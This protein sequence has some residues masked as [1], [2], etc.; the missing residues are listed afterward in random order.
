MHQLFRILFHSVSGDLHRNLCQWGDV[1]KIHK[2]SVDF[3]NHFPDL[4][5]E[6][7]V[8]AKGPIV[9]TITFV[10]T[11]ACPLRCSYC[12]EC[13]KDHSARMSKETA[14]AAVD[15]ILHPERTK[16]YINMAQDKGVILDFIGGEPLLE[17]ELLEYI[18]DYFKMKVTMM[19]HPWKNH[20]MFSVTS[21]GIPWKD[22][23]VKRFIQKNAGRLSLTV[24]VDGDKTL[25]DS[26]RVFP[27]GSGSYEEAVEAV[28]FFRQYVR[29]TNTKAT[30]APGNIQYISKS[31]PHLF[32]LGFTDIHANCVYEEGWTL[33]DAQLFYSE[34]VKLAD[35]MVDEKVYEYGACSI[36]TDTIGKY[37]GPEETQNW[38]G[39]DGKMLAIGTDGRAFPCI[40]YMSYSLSNPDAKEIC[41]GDVW[42]GL[43]SPE[44]N[45]AL[46]C[47]T[48]L[49][50][51]SQS[52]QECLD[53]PV[54]TGCG[55][56]SAY[57]YDRYGTANK[58]ATF[59]CWTH[60]ARCMANAY[61]WNRIKEATGYDARAENN[62][63]P[64][65]QELL[66]GGTHA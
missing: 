32:S 19:D 37:Q 15:M 56:C 7:Q 22:P 25:H 24:T 10:V 44:E 16:G 17:P 11:E 13:N 8:G 27:D 64:D 55:W 66:R 58:R 54:S 3:A 52:T 35:W 29:M 63:H 42:E 31:I 62:V 47:L 6:L 50:R 38:C 53:C 49:T 61:Y 36:F 33:E 12:Y 45:Q 57:N 43:Q 59:I 2:M 46:R 30:F 18:T 34:L 39:G 51:Q 60:R 9:K 20:Y 26:C 1:M 5:P 40:R 14:R 48:C 4:F 65:H 41:I 23:A 21:N 28:R